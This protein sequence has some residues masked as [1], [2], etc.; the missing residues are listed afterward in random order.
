MIL[1]SYNGVISNVL[2]PD[3]DGV[4]DA[5]YV[6]NVLFYLDSDVKIYNE[7]GM[8]IYSAAPYKND[9]KGTYNGNKLP[10]GTYYYVLKFKNSNLTLKGSINLISSS[11]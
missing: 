7:Y 3:G 6:E 10:D 11:K 5:W 9:W 4:N 1:G 8:E 2:T